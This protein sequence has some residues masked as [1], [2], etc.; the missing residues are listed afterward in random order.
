MPEL[1]PPTA[2]LHRAWLESRDEWGRGVHQA[3]SGLRP[4]DEVDSP[5][6]FAAW[7]TRLNDEEDPAKPVR[8]DWVHCT[9]RWMVEDGRVLG[10]ISLR[11]E[12]SDFLLRAGGHVGYGVRPSAR[13]RGLATWALSETVRAAGKLGIGRVLVT[14]DVT[15]VASA[16][17]I[18]NA[19]GV[20]EDVRD[21][22]IGRV[23]RYWVTL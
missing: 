18:E 22:E 3:G 11:H 13:R 6:G 2:R 21:T 16:R 10:A 19:G 7:V 8:A 5:A 9:Y 4:G 23:R 14:C 12:L 1:I 17:T 20:L 15:N